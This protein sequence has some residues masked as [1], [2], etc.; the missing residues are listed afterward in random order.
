MIGSQIAEEVE[1][2]LE[3]S[4]VPDYLNLY[5]CFT[6]NGSVVNCEYWPEDEHHSDED[7][8]H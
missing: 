5:G 3:E 2:K 4:S 8:F 1:L 7:L 6:Q